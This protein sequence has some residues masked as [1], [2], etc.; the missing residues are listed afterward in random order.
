MTAGVVYT[1]A[2]LDPFY[3]IPTDWQGT[4]GQ[5]HE[6]NW[7][8]SIVNQNNPQSPSYTTET[9]TFTWESRE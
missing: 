7:T 9:Y 5:R 1:A 4:N 2:T 8:V 3:V 6:Y